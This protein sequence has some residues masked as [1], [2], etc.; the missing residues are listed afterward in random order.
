MPV[1]SLAAIAVLKIVAYLDRPHERER[2]LADLAHILD[3]YVSGDDERLF[4]DEV[5]ADLE[6]LYR[7]AF[8]LGADLASLVNAQE[9]AVVTRFVSLGRGAGADTTRS[10][11]LRLGPTRWRLAGRAEEAEEELDAMLT[12]LEAGLVATT[13]S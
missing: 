7:P 2:D 10:R 1:P 13:T 4:G 12:A 11:L 6:L 8:L 5:P 3:A 9:H